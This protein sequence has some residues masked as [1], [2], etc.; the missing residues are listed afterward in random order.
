MHLSTWI[1]ILCFVSQASAFSLRTMYCSKTIVLQ[2]VIHDCSMR[3]MPATSQRRISLHF[4]T[5]HNNAALP[6]GSTSRPRYIC[7]CLLS[8]S[9][10]NGSFP[11]LLDTLY[12]EGPAEYINLR[13]IILL[14]YGNSINEMNAT[15]SLLSRAALEKAS[16]LL[17]LSRSL[18]LPRAFSFVSLFL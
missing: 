15:R 7:F 4:P 14:M 8:N 12:E 10:T 13:F 18:I 6:G 3:D 17:Q 16:T 1:S 2:S 11:R 5:Y 9:L